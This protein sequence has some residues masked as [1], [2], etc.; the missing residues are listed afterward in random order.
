MWVAS[1]AGL[2]TRDRLTGGR[3]ELRGE[4]E[5]HLAETV[6]LGLGEIAFDQFVEESVA[7]CDDRTADLNRQHPGRRPTH[8]QEGTTYDLEVFARLGRGCE[9]DERGSCLREVDRIA[10]QRPVA[11]GEQSGRRCARIAVREEDLVD[12]PIRV[13][14]VDPVL[15]FRTCPDSFYRI[16]ERGEPLSVEDVDDE[17]VAESVE[18]RRVTLRRALQL[19]ALRVSWGARVV[20][21][22]GPVMTVSRNVSAWVSDRTAG[23]T[24]CAYPLRKLSPV[25]LESV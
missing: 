22:A 3:I 23:V 8:C 10:P 16:P 20:S 2:S 17:S 21:G 24:R 13:R 11:L 9:E 25:A 19:R 1:A 15:L 7:A 4:I 6:G 14:N 5:E 12:S 18:K